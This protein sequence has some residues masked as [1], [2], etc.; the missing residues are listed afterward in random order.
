MG[1]LIN[2]L[3]LPVTPIKMRMEYN[4]IVRTRVYIGLK[5]GRRWGT[6]RSGSEQSSCVADERLDEVHPS[7]VV[8]FTSRRN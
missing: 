3:L 4:T 7:V 1:I 8:R 6:L 5:K 2:S